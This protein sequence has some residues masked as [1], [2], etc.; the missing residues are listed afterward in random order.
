MFLERVGNFSFD[1]LIFLFLM[2]FNSSKPAALEST[3][4]LNDSMNSERSCPDQ[5]HRFI[6]SSCPCI[7]PD[8]TVANE[9]LVQLFLELQ[10]F[11]PELLQLWVRLDHV[12]PALIA[13]H[14]G[15]R[16]GVISQTR[17]FRKSLTC[18]P[19]RL[20]LAIKVLKLQI[21]R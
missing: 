5:G 19:T 1:L 14:K 8:C 11:I 7:L 12:I 2:F 17:V 18:L 10:G 16:I 9:Q 3:A 20:E 6:S 4:V 21:S 15:H 13:K